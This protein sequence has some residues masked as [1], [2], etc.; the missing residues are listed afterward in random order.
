LYTSLEAVV[1]PIGPRPRQVLCLRRPK[2][3]A[4]KLTGLV[5]MRAFA[6]AWPESA[7]VHGKPHRCADL[8]LFGGLFT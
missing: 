6:A 4:R 8:R 5:Y 3:I 2:A 7:F 1:L